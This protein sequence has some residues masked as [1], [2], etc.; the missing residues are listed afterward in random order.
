MA[1]ALGSLSASAQ[2]LED[3][4]LQIH[5]YAT[6]GFLYT[7]QNN[8]FTAT[9]SNGSPAWTEAVLNVTT[10]PAPKLR[11]AAQARYLLLGN[12]GDGTTITLDW[13]SADYKFNDKFGVRFGKVKTPW[14]L[15]N[16]IQDID[17]A[18]IWSL[19]PQGIY[20]LDNRQAYLTHYGGVV[21]GTL[22]L[23]TAGKL[24][25][26]GWG[27]EGYYPSGDGYF[28]NQAQAGYSLPDDIHGPLLGAALH[29]RT[30]LAGLM[31]GAS[32]LR[33]NAWSAVQNFTNTQGIFAGSYMLAA[34]S[35]P[36]YFAKFEKNKVMAAVEYQR[37]WGNEVNLFPTIPSAAYSERNDDRSIYAMATYKL[38]AKLTGGIYN[39]Q[40]SDHQAPLGPG[41]YQK[42]WAISGRYDFNAFLYAKAEQHFIDGNGLNYDTQLNPNLQP[43]TR[44]T[45]LKVGVSF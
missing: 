1:L 15:F 26:R 25:Y 12:Y 35:Q 2:S 28:V 24:E 41:R 32:D 34:N 9:S 36:N 23:R 17:P 40:N 22:N 45:A 38:T 7:T 30:P 6:Q 10:Q 29:W 44:L 3:L 31:I 13:A 39:S 16:E 19:L 21:Y 33:D 14:G 43:N 18:Y 4:N 8:I 37:S 5:G 20:P 42:D 11:V 27:G